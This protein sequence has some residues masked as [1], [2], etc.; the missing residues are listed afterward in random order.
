MPE[1]ATLGLFQNKVLCN[2]V[3]APTNADT[4][5]DHGN[6]TVKEENK[7]FAGKHELILHIIAELL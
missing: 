1:V 6:L 3:N 5:R 2:I 4:Y 7:N